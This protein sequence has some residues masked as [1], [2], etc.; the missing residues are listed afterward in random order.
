MGMAQ[1]M[2]LG[3]SS[4]YMKVLMGFLSIELVL[5]SLEWWR[6][7]VFL[8]YYKIIKEPGYYKDGSFGIRIENLIL[9]VETAPNFWGFENLTICPYDMN[10]MDHSLLNP[11][12][13]GYIN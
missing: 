3:T 4:M 9:G 8:I 6:A 7:M 11:E 10:L 12:Y 13:V 5:L 1:G 2:E